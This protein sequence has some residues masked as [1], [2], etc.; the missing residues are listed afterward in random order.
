[1]KKSTFSL[2]ILSAAI[3]GSVFAHGASARFGGALAEVDDMYFELVNK[4]GAGII[5]VTEDHDS[6]VSTKGASGKLIVTNAGKKTEVSLQASGANSLDTKS[7]AKLVPGAKAEATITFAD[8][9]T[10]KV[11]FVSK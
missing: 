4:N 8:K 3:A 1:M 6:E 7:D 11:N 10:V 9:K 2:A 5:Y